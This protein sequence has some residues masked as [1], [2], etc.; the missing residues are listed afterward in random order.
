MSARV[1]SVFNFATRCLGCDKPAAQRRGQRE[2]SAHRTNKSPGDH[3]L[4]P[5]GSDIPLLG[6][7]TPNPG[8][9]GFPSDCDQGGGKDRG[10][11]KEPGREAGGWGGAGDQVIRR[12]INLDGS[13][14]G[15]KKKKT[16]ETFRRREGTGESRQQ[17]PAS[18]QKRS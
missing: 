1:S 16:P 14:G 6:L 9:A 2:S 7:D 8:A 3:R 4:D 13:L 18:G 15:R 11:S 10:R 5:P 17:R 12:I